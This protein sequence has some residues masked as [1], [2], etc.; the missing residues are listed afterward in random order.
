MRKRIKWKRVKTLSLLTALLLSCIVF[1]ACTKQSTQENTQDDL[2]TPSNGV[3]F[4]KTDI[5]DEIDILQL[6]NEYDSS[7]S[8]AEEAVDNVI[9]RKALLK[10]AQDAGYE[11]TDEELSE[12]IE[13]LRESL[14]AAEN[15]TEMQEYFDRFDGE[16]TYFEKFENTYRDNL[17]IR[18]YLDDQKQEYLESETYETDGWSQQE[19][20]IREQSVALLN[21]T[22]DDKQVLYDHALSYIN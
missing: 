13:T 14:N 21:L 9:N 3:S 18:K 11:V 8:L 19:E 20:T 22:E 5:E 16:D 12:Y 7:E 15:T 10:T 6:T 1:A 4:T 17:C 2:I